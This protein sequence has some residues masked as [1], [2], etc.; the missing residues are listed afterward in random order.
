MV[1]CHL[2]DTPSFL[3]PYVHLFLL[4]CY[5]I[6]TFFWEV[7]PI[8]LHPRNPPPP[9]PPREQILNHQYSTQNLSILMLK[10]RH[11]KALIIQIRRV[12]LP[13][14]IQYRCKVL[15]LGIRISFM[16]FGAKPSSHMRMLLP[17]PCL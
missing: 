15:L 7:Q 10:K 2:P 6:L 4:I 9:L 12:S 11:Y 17:D 3:S 8:Y 5:F 13:F 14:C 16:S 1:L